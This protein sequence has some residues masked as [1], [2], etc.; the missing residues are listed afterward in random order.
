[1]MI[2]IKRIRKMIS[3]I[4]IILSFSLAGAISNRI[5]G[6]A[7]LNGGNDT[8]NS[9]IF[10]LLLGLFS[11]N[12]I[13]GVLAAVGMHLGSSFG[14][15][16]YIGATAG[17]EKEKLEEVWFIDF[18]IKPFKNNMRTW[19]F[20]GLSLRGF[21]WG[22]CLVPCILFAKGNLVFLLVP[23]SLMGL[24]YLITTKLQGPHGWESGEIL[25]GAVLWAGVI[26]SLVL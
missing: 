24:C 21:V 3:L 6:G 4:Q 20:L 7:L 23:A 18:L 11:M 12:V 9:L 22:L 15:G 16:R 19:G 5:R 14:W 8:F 2:V 26:A 1:M 13:L 25:Y 17:W 10:G